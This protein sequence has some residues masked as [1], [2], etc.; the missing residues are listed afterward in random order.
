[1]HRCRDGG[2]SSQLIRRCASSGECQGIQTPSAWPACGNPGRMD[3]GEIRGLC[4]AGLLARLAVAA[5]IQA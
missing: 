1:M 2:R 4:F 5:G 3:S